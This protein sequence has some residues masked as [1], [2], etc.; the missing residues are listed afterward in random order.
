M[1]EKP[2]AMLEQRRIEAR[3]IKNIYDVLVE[4][5]GADEAKEVIGKAIISAAIKQGARFRAEHEAENGS[6]PGL[7]DFAALGH[8]WEMDGA[9]VRNVHL[10]SDERLEYDI[11]HCA[12][13]DMYRKMGLG[14]IG[15]LL[16]CNRD[17]TFC[18]GYNP[19]M[20]LTRTQTIMNGA[21]HCDFRYRMKKAKS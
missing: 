14:H 11:V 10:E 17:G 18:V 2:L 9:L 7:L 19:A 6:E 12:Y 4:H 15:H 21:P 1:S 13:A 5:H 16:S 8:L 3:L 20:E